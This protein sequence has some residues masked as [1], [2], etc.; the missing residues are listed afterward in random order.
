[1]FVGCSEI[2]KSVIVK[3][4]QHIGIIR[5]F[6]LPGGEGVGGGVLSFSVPGGKEKLL[7]RGLLGGISTQADTM[8]YSKHTIKISLAEFFTEFYYCILF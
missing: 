8:N 5:A 3:H 4:K 7:G 6:C 2:S 1:M